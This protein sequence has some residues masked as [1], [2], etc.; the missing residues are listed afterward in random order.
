MSLP[1]ATPIVLPVFVVLDGVRQL[2]IFFIGMVANALILSP[3]VDS[4]GFAT[5]VMKVRFIRHRKVE[6]VMLG[7]K[8]QLITTKFTPF[9][10]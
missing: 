8:F 6:G 3:L 10:L 4:H 7:F 1:L 5:M 2:L 9:F